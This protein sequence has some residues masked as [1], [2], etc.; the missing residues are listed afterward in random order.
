[1]IRR[2]WEEFSITMTKLENITTHGDKK[3]FPKNFIIKINNYS[4]KIFMTLEK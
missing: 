2:L 1:M 3:K 4:Y